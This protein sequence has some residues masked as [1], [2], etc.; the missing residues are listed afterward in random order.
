[1]E[2]SIVLFEGDKGVLSI[3]LTEEETGAGVRVSVVSK[4]S[5]AQTL[6]NMKWALE[7]A[8]VVWCGP[9]ALN[10]EGGDPIGTEEAE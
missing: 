9:A 10:S 7:S 4:L 6:A 5:L 3:V 8:K 2:R 1:M